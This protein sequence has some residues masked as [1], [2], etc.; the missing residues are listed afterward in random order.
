VQCV[1]VWKPL[2]AH[3]VAVSSA[4]FAGRISIRDTERRALS[5]VI[6]RPSALLLS[7]APILAP[8]LSMPGVHCSLSRNSEVATQVVE[9]DAPAVPPTALILRPSVAHEKVLSLPQTLPRRCTLATVLQGE[10]TWPLN[11]L[12]ACCSTTSSALLFPM[13]RADVRRVI[14]PDAMVALSTLPSLRAIASSRV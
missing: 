6:L 9:W 13:A 12:L 14:P 10:F 5:L 11:V 1:R 8:L 7:C 2:R 4:W 3:C